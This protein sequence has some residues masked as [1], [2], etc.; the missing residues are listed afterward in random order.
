MLFFLLSGRLPFIAARVEEFEKLVNHTVPNWHHMGNASPEAHDLCRKM[1]EKRVSKRPSAAAARND[2]WFAAVGLD[3]ASTQKLAKP[4]L[5]AL[6]KVMDRGVFEK[7]IT[8][9]VATQVDASKFRIVNEA[10]AAFDTDG[11]GQLSKAELRDGLQRARAPT[12]T[13]DQVF[14]ELDVGGTGF[15]SYTEFLAGTINLSGKKTEEQDNFLWVAWQQFSPDQNGRVSHTAV[16]DSLASRGMTVADLP[17]RFLEELSRG[18]TGELTFDS[19]K[20]LLV[21]DVRPSLVERMSERLTGE[22]SKTTRFTR[23]LM[24][25]N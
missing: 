3:T 7:F 23:W 16:Q 5:E 20:K 22:N 12:A 1:L 13:V 2:R 6:L 11:D 21:T 19:F 10:F 8:R 9:L 25:K 18:A 17:E 15:I 24:Q 4:Q 14:E